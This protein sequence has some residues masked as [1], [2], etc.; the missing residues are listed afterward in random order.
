MKNACLLSRKRKKCFPP[1]SVEGAL[2]WRADPLLAPTSLSSSCFPRHRF[3]HATAG[4]RLTC[5]RTRLPAFACKRVL[6]LSSRGTLVFSLGPSA[7]AATDRDLS[8]EGKNP[9]GLLSTWLSFPPREAFC[10]HRIRRE[11][12]RFVGVESEPVFRPR[13]IA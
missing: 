1:P 7:Y 11:N 2:T 8:R 12:A 9:P 5:H 10:L 4:Q 6:T 13:V 3:P